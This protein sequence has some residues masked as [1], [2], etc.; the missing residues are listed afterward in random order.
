MTGAGI[1]VLCCEALGILF[2]ACLAALAIGWTR[3]K[4]R[5]WQG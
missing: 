3:H 2:L 4:L 1:V 5:N